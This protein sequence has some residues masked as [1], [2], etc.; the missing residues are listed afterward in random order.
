MDSETVVR[1][2]MDLSQEGKFDEASRYLDDSM[3]FIG[4]TP[5]PVSKKD[6]VDLTKKLVN[7]MPDWRFNYRD[8]HTQGDRVSMTVQITGTQSREIQPLMPGMPL[9][10]VTGKHISLP[11]QTQYATVHNDKITRLEVEDIPGGGL[12]GILQQLGIDLPR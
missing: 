3:L 5:E 6:F 12:M 1:K 7:A 10:P 9:I 8:L 2:F 11:N 4:A